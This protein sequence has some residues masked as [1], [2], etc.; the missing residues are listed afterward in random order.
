MRGLPAV[1]T[2]GNTFTRDVSVEEGV[3]TVEQNL[4][5]VVGFVTF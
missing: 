1:G 5:I 2:A 3:K 4:L